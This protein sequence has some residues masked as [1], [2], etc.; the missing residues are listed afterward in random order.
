MYVYLCICTSYTNTKSKQQTTCISYK[1]IKYVS[2]LTTELSL[3]FVETCKN[4]WI[5]I[6]TSPTQELVSS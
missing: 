3:N 2:R 5:N 6:H 4:N 1:S